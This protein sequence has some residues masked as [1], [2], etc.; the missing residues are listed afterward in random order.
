[1]TLDRLVSAQPAAGYRLARH[2]RQRTRLPGGV[3]PLADDAAV[4]LRAYLVV[5]DGGDHGVP[6][7]M[8][9]GVQL[10]AAVRGLVQVQAGEDTPVL[11][12]GDSLLAETVN[13]RGWRNLRPDPAVLYWVLRD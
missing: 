3:I 8:H 10:V 6:P 5:L 1:V 11:R 2:D 12:A 7:V 9:S 13:I 4:G